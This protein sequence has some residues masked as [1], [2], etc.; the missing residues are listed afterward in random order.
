LWGTLEYDESQ[1]KE[2]TVTRVLIIE[3]DML[4]SRMYM[5]IFLSNKYDVEI[6]TNGQEGL[7][8]ARDTKPTLILLDIMMPKLNGIEVLRKL[9]NDP[10]VKD[11]P[12]VVLT[13]LAGNQDIQTALELGAVRYIIKSE[14]KPKQ[15]EEIVREI[16][17]GY[18]RN[19]VPG[20]PTT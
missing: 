8:K 16:L 4:L 3:D 13:N 1:Y 18:T 20:T 17:V 10:E 9:K 12:V 19:E 2:I 11:I 6:A 5:T 14:Q 15:V 7:D